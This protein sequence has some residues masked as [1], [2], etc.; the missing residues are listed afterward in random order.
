M[1]AS[2]TAP[3][4]RFFAWWFGELAACVP[5][6]LRGALAG[7]RQQIAIDYRERTVELHHRARGGWRTLGSVAVDRDAPAAGRAACLAVLRGIRRG[8]VEIVLRLPAAQVLQRRVDM[9]LAAAENLREVLGFEMDRL[10]PFKSANAA[11]DYRIAV[12]DRETQRLTVDLTVA[13]RTFVEEAVGVATALG[14]AP[15]RVGVANG[16]DAGAAPINLM[17]ATSDGGGR[18]LG[19]LTLALAAL[20]CLLL[21]AT[22][23][24]PLHREQEEL[25]ALEARLQRSRAE[26]TAA[27]RLRAQLAEVL[28]RKTF[29]VQRRQSTPLTVTVLKDLTERLADDTWLVQLHIGDGQ[30]MLS[31]YAPAAASLVPTLEDSDLLSDVRFSSPVMPDTR[32]GRERFNLSAKIAGMGGG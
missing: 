15:D 26:A 20:F 4:A 22:V 8:A 9:P 28:D 19:R 11:Y 7:R 5:A 12:T 6:G 32:V 24:W 21:G 29:L 31:G 14:L 27:D 1:M 30:V 10:T 16:L 18:F 3:I 23:L 13:P 17:S 25:A 2:L